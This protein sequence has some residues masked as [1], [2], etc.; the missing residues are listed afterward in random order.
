MSQFILPPDLEITSPKPTGKINPL[1]K[2]FYLGLFSIEIQVE[3]EYLLVEQLKLAIS[4]ITELS[5]QEFDSENFSWKIEYAS[6][7]LEL[8]V[9][10]DL[11][12][13]VLIGKE[14]ATLASIEAI[15]RFPHLI[16]NLNEEIHEHPC[17]KREWHK[18]EIDLFSLPESNKYIIH[19][20][21]LYGDHNSF[22]YT[23]GRIINMLFNMNNLPIP[24]KFQYIVQKYN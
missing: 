2:V 19:F 14:A 13:T 17:E 11:Y 8:S 18:S 1:P 5:L 22:Y 9:S 15:Q 20:N 6:K 4:N 23:M 10:G 12:Q 3:S 16:P 24:E 7:P 21:R